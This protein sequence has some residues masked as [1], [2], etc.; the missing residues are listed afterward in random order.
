M[1][2]GGAEL[3]YPAIKSAFPL[4]KDKVKILPNSQ[5]ALVI[6]IAEINR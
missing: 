6:S 3:I 4:L 1:T 2:G 5:L